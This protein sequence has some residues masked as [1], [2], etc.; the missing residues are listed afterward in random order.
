M[1]TVH[2]DLPRIDA[3]T[4]PGKEEQ[5]VAMPICDPGRTESKS[6]TFLP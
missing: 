6:E 1:G 5:L 4:Q 2:L 3:V